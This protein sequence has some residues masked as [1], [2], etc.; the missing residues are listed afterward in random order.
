MMLSRA[1][2]KNV[3]KSS[4]KPPEES[5]TDPGPS[6]QPEANSKLQSIKAFRTISAM[7]SSIPSDRVINVVDRKSERGAKDKELKLLNALATLLVRRNEVAA[8][9]VTDYDNGLGAI[10]VIACHHVSSDSPS[11]DLIF[12]PQPTSFFKKLLATFNPRI[13]NPKFMSERPTIH[14][15]EVLQDIQETEDTKRIL[16]YCLINW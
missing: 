10:Q 15:P 6:E 8:V 12:P 3:S 2:K 14:N 5:V 13:D 4:S 1:F 9:A 11:G 16:E 7:L